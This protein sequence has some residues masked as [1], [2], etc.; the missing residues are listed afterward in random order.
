MKSATQEHCTPTLRSPLINQA[1][2]R[3][4][5]SIG[6]SVAGLN[7]LTACDGDTPNAQRRG[8][9]T[10]PDR[11]FYIPPELDMAL[12]VSPTLDD[13]VSAERGT[14]GGP[15][16][17]DTDCQGRACVTAGE[18]R[19]CSRSCVSIC[20]PFPDGQ[21]AYCRYDPAQNTDNFVCYPSQNRLCQA[22]LDAS[23]CDGA[24]CIETSEGKRCTQ[25]CRAQEDCPS[26]FNCQEGACY[27]LN[28]SCD[29]GPSN[30]GETRVC[31]LQNAHGRCFGEERCDPDQ[32]WVGCDAQT[33]AEERCDGLD[34]NCN[35]L[36]DEE[37]SS[38]TCQLSNE[39][40]SCEGVEVCIGEGGRECYGATPT[41][42]RCD[43]IDNDC[44]GLIDE[45]Y[46]LADGR[47]GLDAHCGRCGNSCEG[48][49]Q[50]ATAVSC[51]A[52]R[53]APTCVA[54]DCEPGFQLI[55]GVAC[56][57][58]DDV[59]CAP[60]SD[61]A[62][63]STRSPGAACVGIGDPS[64][65]ETLISVCGRDCSP[66]GSFGETCPAGYSCQQV[67]SDEGI[68][69]QC[70]PEAGHCLCLNQPEGFSI[71][72]EVESPL[73]PALSCQGRRECE[74][75]SFGECVLPEEECDGRDND[76]DGIIDNGFR[77]PDGRYSLDPRHCGRCQLSCDQLSF[78][79][80]EASCDLS[81][82]QPRCEMVCA[83]GF[84]DLENG[85]DDGCECEVIPGEDHP[86]GLD[87]NC[88][89][90]DGDISRALFV[91][92]TGDDQ[93]PGTL[94]QPL[95]SVTRALTLASGPQAGIRDIYVATGVYSENITLVDGVSVYGGYSLDFRDRD[96]AEHPTTL[97]GR[98]VSGEAKGTLT[99]VNITQPTQVNGFSIYGANANVPSGNS[100]AV[101]L[102]NSS[103]ALSLRD[104]ELIAGNGAP[105]QRGGAGL[106]GALGVNGQRGEDAITAASGTC[107]NEDTAGGLGG[108]RSCG[109]LNVKGGK[110]GSGHCPLTQ[111]ISGTIG[112]SS[113]S[114][115]SC[116]NSCET[117]ACLP[118]PPPQ[119][120]GETG[121]GSASALATG[122]GP[123][124][125]RWSNSGNCSLC[126]LVPELPHLGNPGMNGANGAQGSPGQGCLNSQ[127]SL[128]AQLV[129]VSASGQSGGFGLHGTGGGGGSA[130]S[131][132]DTTVLEAGCFDTIGG[133]GG[134]GGSGGCGGQAGQ[135]GSG[136]GG[137]FAVLIAYGSQ[138]APMGFPELVGN[139]ISRGIG[140]QGG[141][142]GSGGIGGLGGEGADGGIATGAFCAEPGGRGGN[143]GDGGHGGG[144]GGGCGGLSTGVYISGTLAGPM[145]EIYRTSND[146]T[147]SGRAGLGGQG[148]GSTGQ[149]GSAGQPGVL[150][151]VISVE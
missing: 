82:P 112:C 91:S 95:L 142:G 42:E 121:S 143:G 80:A 30:E 94:N 126:G 108:V 51:D 23:Q 38:T 56:I 120:E 113:A 118:L 109:A 21:A 70:L 130:G 127:G 28:G 151:D 41:E 119:G 137:S 6:L 111:W 90:V 74:G 48:Q 136:G 96:P 89:G 150:S 54:D 67:L 47:Y 147:P 36:I 131:G 101:Y 9:M 107:L 39:H 139:R 20:E 133:S 85:S 97:F 1:H 31:E 128:N 75:S 106:S 98:P 55:D 62:T 132:Y 87:R 13:S 46:T 24:P 103:S 135:G 18:A 104:N 60:C 117:S 26:D 73:N 16:E 138:G 93:A 7:L 83:P 52:D 144:G 33:P 35:G 84:V 115:T 2:L 19:I 50:Y 68:T 64:V 8:V 57:P 72:C 12:I 99:A 66:A 116:R 15:C 129:W 59:I 71:P 63:C 27:P 17:I 3:T 77:T 114:P 10:E 88:D 92:K 100:V 146:L 61:S 43:L 76:C 102:I 4:A 65:P 69:A 122:G 49:V 29:C 22:C 124:Y 44:D 140:G 123:T 14:Y 40:G 79:N 78:P 125:D 58:T 5:L 37:V 105:G 110:G 32:G 34:Q 81:A 149:P 45:G 141:A 148:G 86:D 134:G 53:A 25:P 11:G 145:V